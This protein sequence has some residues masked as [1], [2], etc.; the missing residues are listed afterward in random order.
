MDEFLMAGSADDYKAAAALFKEYAAGLN[1]DLGFQHFEKEL[2]ELREMYALPNGGVIL[3][4]K[5]NEFIA[6]VAIRRIDGDYA[7]LKRMFVKPAYQRR[8]I[9]KQLLDK[10]LELARNC[11]Y[12]YV[13]LD[14]LDH[15]TAAVTLYKENG[16]HE[17]NAYYHNP[18]SSAVYFEKEL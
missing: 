18:I 12:K 15:M 5:E 8:R 3:C 17:I 13:R 10:A 14:T 7:E 6:C 4:K 2:Q 16:F 1:I 11:H 9:G